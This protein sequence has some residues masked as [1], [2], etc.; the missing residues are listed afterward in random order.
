MSKQRVCNLKDSRAS[1]NNTFLS[2]LT[3]SLPEASKFDDDNNETTLNRDQ[4]VYEHF[5]KR[6]E[7]LFQ[8]KSRAE[9]KVINYMTEVRKN[10]WLSRYLLNINT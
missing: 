2:T 1:A 5:S 8:E 4:I 9:S 3:F 10:M 6:F 7:E